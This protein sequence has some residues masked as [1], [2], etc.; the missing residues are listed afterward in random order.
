[1]FVLES[2]KSVVEQAEHVG[3]D[4]GAI[5]RWA[6][7]VT[8]ESL[9]PAGHELLAHLPGTREQLANLVLL[10]E[11]LNFCFWSPDPIRIQWRGKTYERFNAM[12]VSLMLAA[13]YDPKWFEAEF[14]VCVPR[15]EL[16]EVLSGKGELLLLEEREQVI[17]ETGRALL[18]RFD[19]Q[20][21]HAVESVNERAWPLAVLLM[22]NFESFRDVSRYRGQPV[23]F[24]KRAQICALDL[25]V[26]WQQHDHPPLS[27]L[28]KLTAF[29]DYRIP[30]ALV[31]LGILKYAPEL[32]ETVER[33]REIGKDSPEE[34]EIRAASIQ[35]VD[36]MVRAAASADKGVPAWQIDWHLWQVSHDISV[37][38]NHHR[39]RTVYYLIGV[40]GQ[41]SGAST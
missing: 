1:M 30:Q 13:K 25:S 8:V 18:E 36:R 16:R 20:F 32:A 6:G 14:W 12:L 35:A 27:G 19:G 7:E 40:R 26:V 33:E 28:E 15:D 23:Y 9:R 34:I 17:R 31:H 11:S 39:T 24:M 37:E 22:T 21:I 10:I 2:T 3:I 5:E 29:A 38:V 4:D 41:G